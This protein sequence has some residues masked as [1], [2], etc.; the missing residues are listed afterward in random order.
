MLVML[1]S[2]PFDSGIESAITTEVGSCNHYRSW[3]LQIVLM[4]LGLLC[5]VR[6]AWKQM[7]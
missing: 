2:K 5:N 7:K 3:K 4:V 6:R 1:D